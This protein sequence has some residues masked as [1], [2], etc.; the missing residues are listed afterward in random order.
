MYVYLKD[1]KI[2]FFLMNSLFGDLMLLLA[3]RL[4]ELERL[5]KSLYLTLATQKRLFSTHLKSKKL[6]LNCP[7][8]SP[9]A[10]YWE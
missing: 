7:P 5:K 3:R 10:T 8:P 9:V 4:T 6:K 2:K 1:R